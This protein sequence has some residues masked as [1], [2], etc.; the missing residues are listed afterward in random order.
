MN[1]V[2]NL[3]LQLLPLAGRDSRRCHVGEKLP[4]Y[5]L[6]WSEEIILRTGGL[7]ESKFES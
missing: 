3:G 4:Q 1:K 5:G 6:E 2:L 7:L